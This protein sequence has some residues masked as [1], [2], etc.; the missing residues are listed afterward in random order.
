M[1]IL[2][3]ATIINFIL[4]W[5]SSKSTSA[6]DALMPLVFLAMLEIALK[7]CCC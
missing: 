5:F 1:K 3:A 7:S 4:H 6:A 2:H